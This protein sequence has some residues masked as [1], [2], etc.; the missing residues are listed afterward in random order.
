[1]LS[2]NDIS[3]SDYNNLFKH[4]D[5]LLKAIQVLLTSQVTSYLEKICWRISVTGKTLT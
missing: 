4:F 2:E 3:R 1:M 5:L